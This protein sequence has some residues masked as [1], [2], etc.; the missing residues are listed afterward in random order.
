VSRSAVALLVA[1]MRRVISIEGVATALAV[2]APLLLRLLG[3][4]AGLL[5]TIIFLAA[6]AAAYFSILDHVAQGR[7]ELPKAGDESLGKKFWRG[8]AVCIAGWLP[9]ILVTVYADDLGL[10]RASLFGAMAG[11]VL[12]GALLLPA[13][14]LAVYAA[15]SALAALAPHLWVMIISRM[16]RDYLSVAWLYVLLLGVA[17]FVVS[18]VAAVPVLGAVLAP[19][20]R[21]MTVFAMAAALGGVVHR[22]RDALGI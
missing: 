3:G 11:A 5:G 7:A 16:P 8:L 14:S 17:T 18:M 2:C 9:L 22:N 19:L 10:A 21:C 4:L 1:D 6:L 12:F 15:D 13:A 20:L